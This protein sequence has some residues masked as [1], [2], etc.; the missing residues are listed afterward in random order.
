MDRVSNQAASRWPGCVRTAVLILVGA[1]LASCLS[2]AVA[3][4]NAVM[5]ITRVGLAEMLIQ[6]LSQ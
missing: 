2:A 1:V 4:D 3:G 6:K 5:D